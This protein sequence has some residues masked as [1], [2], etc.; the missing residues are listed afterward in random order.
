MFGILLTGCLP[1]AVPNSVKRNLS[2]KL[3]SKG[4]GLNAKLNINGYFQYWRNDGITYNTQTQER[5]TS[6][7]FLL[8]YEDGSFLFSSLLKNQMGNTPE[9]YFKQVIQNG[10]EHRFYST[11]SWGIYRLSGDTIIAESLENST[12][13]LNHPWMPGEYRYRIVN[14]NTLQLID[15]RNFTDKSATIGEETKNFLD[16]VS[17]ITFFPSRVPPSYSWLKK[18]KFFWRREA[19]W[20][21]YMEAD[22]KD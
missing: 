15:S 12:R 5:D 6:F 11:G 22:E 21:A 16:N 4:T 18:D 13:S 19:D 17:L 1:R 8:F 20:K 10:K 9:E 2:N 3:D 14:R 7:F